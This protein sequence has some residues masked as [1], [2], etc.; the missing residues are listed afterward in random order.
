VLVALK[1]GLLR[2]MRSDEMGGK[3]TITLRPADFTQQAEDDDIAGLFL[4]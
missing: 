2:V 1:Q 4:H 3:I